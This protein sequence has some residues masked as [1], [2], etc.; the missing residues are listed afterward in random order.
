MRA[1]NAKG[2]LGGHR[3]GRGSTVVSSRAS[4][5]AAAVGALLPNGARDAWREEWRA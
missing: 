1:G 4:G 3:A 5:A 2:F